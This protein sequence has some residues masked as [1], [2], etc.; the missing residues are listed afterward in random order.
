[1]AAPGM[2]RAQVA[3]L[4][5]LGGYHVD[6]VTPAAG[7]SCPYLLLMETRE[8]PGRAGDGWLLVTRERRSTNDDE[9]TA[10]YRRL[11]TQQSRPAPEALGRDE[12]AGPDLRRV[13]IA[14]PCSIRAVP[15]GAP[16]H[17]SGR[18]DQPEHRALA[19]LAAMSSSPPWRCTTCLTIDR[20]RPVPP[21]SRERLPS[22]R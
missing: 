14:A 2:P 1:M 4:E 15:P 18:K 20:P 11:R 16:A 12:S 10:I 13:N 21:V 7:T 3:A 17:T 22:T 5:Y 9:A 6:A 8:Q 19:D